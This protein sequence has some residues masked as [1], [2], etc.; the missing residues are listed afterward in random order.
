[1]G[2][3]IL[4]WRN[5][6][7]IH[8]WHFE[9][10]FTGAQRRR[11]CPGFYAAAG[12]AAASLPSASSLKFCKFRPSEAEVDLCKC[13]AHQ[14]KAVQLGLESNSTE[15]L[16]HF[17]QKCQV[18]HMVLSPWEI[19]FSREARI[20][21]SPR[22]LGA[23]FALEVLKFFVTILSWQWK[24]LIKPNFPLLSFYF[25][26][27]KTLVKITLNYY[28]EIMLHGNSMFCLSESL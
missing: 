12:W 14:G 17:L 20:R 9:R 28:W 2:R 16:A 6:A 21:W 10:G 19:L 11:T 18:L 22:F 5:S 25:K 1:M 4:V 15:A 3:Q 26:I 27:F 24:S 23:L 8:K 13:C 7:A